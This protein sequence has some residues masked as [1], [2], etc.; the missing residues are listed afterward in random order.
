MSMFISLDVPEFCILEVQFLI[1]QLWI[2]LYIVT[3]Y[4]DLHNSLVIFQTHEWIFNILQ[5]ILLNL[6]QHILLSLLLQYGS[7]L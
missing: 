1:P 4:V 2:R 3:A 7:M 6:I 5:V